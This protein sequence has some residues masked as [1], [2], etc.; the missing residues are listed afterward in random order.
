MLRK[1]QQPSAATGS[2]T[3]PSPEPA[4]T[5]TLFLWR[6]DKL[7]TAEAILMGLA[8]PQHQHPRP[9]RPSLLSGPQPWFHTGLELIPR[10]QSRG[11]VQRP[12]SARSTHTLESSQ[13]GLVPNPSHKHTVSQKLLLQRRKDYKEHEC[14]EVRLPSTHSLP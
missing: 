1:V 14:W 3:I 13:E 9:Q 10:G 8:T 7:S 12:S 6:R 4:L 2:L 11:T 5:A